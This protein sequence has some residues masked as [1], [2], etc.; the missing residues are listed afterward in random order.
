MSIPPTEPDD[1]MKNE[2]LHNNGGIEGKQEIQDG[3]KYQLHNNDG[4]QGELKH[5]NETKTEIKDGAISNEPIHRLS[6]YMYY[7]MLRRITAGKFK[8]YLMKT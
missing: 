4:K 1:D 5:G 8:L 3:K 2:E 6:H 7:I